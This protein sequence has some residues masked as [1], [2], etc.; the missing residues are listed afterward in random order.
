MSDFKRTTESSSNYND[1]EKMSALELLT[2]I[3]REDQTV[4]T[5]VNTE[6]SII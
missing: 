6:V 3:N 1:L 5:A 2:K 4:A